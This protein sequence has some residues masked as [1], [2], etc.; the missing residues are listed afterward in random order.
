ME[1][2]GNMDKFGKVETKDYLKKQ[3]KMA[4]DN[5]IYKANKVLERKKPRK[6]I[7]YFYK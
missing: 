7:F 5:I 1:Y 6:K 3:Y 2:I 4:S